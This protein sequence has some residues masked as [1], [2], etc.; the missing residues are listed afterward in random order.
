VNGWLIFGVFVV[1]CVLAM[2]LGWLMRGKEV[3]ELKAEHEFALKV[4]NSNAFAAGADF[5]QEQIAEVDRKL[6][7]GDPDAPEPV[8][9]LRA[10]PRKR[11]S[12]G[13]FA[14]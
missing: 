3:R 8:G 7:F 10:K 14:R 11:D 13:R 2:R 1:A 4:V 5:A 12:H 9:L 6:T